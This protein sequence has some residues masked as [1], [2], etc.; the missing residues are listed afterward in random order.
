MLPILFQFG[1][2]Q[3]LI[4]NATHSDLLQKIRGLKP[5]PVQSKYRVTVTH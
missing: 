1:N 2:G 4:E 5:K 3:I